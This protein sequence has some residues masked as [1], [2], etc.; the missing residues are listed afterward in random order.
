MPSRL[1]LPK[2]MITVSLHK[3]PRFCWDMNHLNINT[4]TQ[5][6]GLLINS[7]RPENIILVFKLM[8]KVPMHH[9]VPNHVHLLK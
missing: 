1:K 9:S 2:K 7:L 6:I 3:F 5:L 4:I 8:G